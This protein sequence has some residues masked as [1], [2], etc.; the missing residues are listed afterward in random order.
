[1][2]EWMDESTRWSPF[3]ACQ[4]RWGNKCTTAPSHHPCT[5]YFLSTF[6]HGQAKRLETYIFCTK[7]WDSGERTLLINLFTSVSITK[8]PMTEIHYKILQILYHI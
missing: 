8:Q 2:L 5:L 6:Y 1:M 7:V 4:W 3:M